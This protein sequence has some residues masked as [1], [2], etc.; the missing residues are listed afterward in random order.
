LNFVYIVDRKV[1]GWG[2][3]ELADRL[4]VTAEVSVWAD[5]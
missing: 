5:G 1:L 3:D 2:A 4:A